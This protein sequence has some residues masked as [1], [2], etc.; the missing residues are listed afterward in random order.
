MPVAQS[1]F[2]KHKPTG[3]NKNNP[4]AKGG[5]R[6]EKKAGFTPRGKDQQ[7]PRGGKPGRPG[8]PAWKKDAGAKPAHAP[9]T[10]GPKKPDSF[11]RETDEPGS[12]LMPLNKYLA[13]SGHGSRRD[14]AT[15]IKDGKVTVNGEVM[16][17]PGYRVLPKDVVTVDGKKAKPQRE[18][19][20]VL[21]N[22]PKDYLTT[23]EDDRG[24]KT[25]MELVRQA[26]DSRLFPIGRLDRQ[27]TGVLLLTNDGDLAQK[28]SHPRY[29][30]R[31][32]YHVTLDKDVTRKDLEQI[33]AGITL[34]DGP[35]KVDEVAYLENKNEIGIQIH[36]GRNRV[37]RRIFESLGYEVTKLD[38][39]VYAGLTKKN[40]AR[41][42]WRYLEEKEI[43]LL[44]HFKG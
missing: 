21:L 10:S 26:A 35:V 40:V 41:G 44:K 5:P 11:K 1:H 17:N 34:D 6:P 43:I 19:V 20:Y 33:A 13:H 37:V 8:K 42:K 16:T 32:I 2:M 27:T 38:R 31:K 25:V 14:A 12:D 4:A 22:K 9:I 15:L 36:I 23:T 7:D 30:V 3:G 18:L 28:L 29:E 39:V 24:R